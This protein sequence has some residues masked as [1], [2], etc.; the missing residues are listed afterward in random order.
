CFVLNSPVRILDAVRQYDQV[1]FA[2]FE[3]PAVRIW[4]A[5]VTISPAMVEPVSIDRL[6]FLGKLC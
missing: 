3:L 2:C 4:D 6:G 1:C 5:S